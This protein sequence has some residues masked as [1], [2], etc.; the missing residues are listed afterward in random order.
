VN[1]LISIWCH[2]FYLS[3]SLKCSGRTIKSLSFP[4]LKLPSQTSLN[5]IAF[6]PE[7]HH[8]GDCHLTPWSGGAAPSPPPADQPAACPA[9]LSSSAWQLS[10]YCPGSD[11]TAESCSLSMQ[12]LA[13]LLLTG[14]ACRWLAK[15][16]WTRSQT[17]DWK[18]SKRLS[19]VLTKLCA[20]SHLM[21]AAG[22]SICGPTSVWDTEV[23]IKV[24][25]VQQ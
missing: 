15:D 22:G 20:D 14:L 1:I 7:G 18:K 21:C 13:E 25:N 2:Y 4:K 5:F 3:W 10:L 8:P 11:C 23:F 12:A 19:T 17:Y 24:I 16:T 6:N 9:L